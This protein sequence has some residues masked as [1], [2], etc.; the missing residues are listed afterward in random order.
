MC[1]S[2]NAKKK[3]IAGFDVG[4]SSL[5]VSIAALDSLSVTENR[6]Y[7]YRGYTE[8]SAGVVPVRIY[9]DN[10]K[11]VLRHIAG[12]YEIAAVS[13]STQMYSICGYIEGELAAYQWNCFWD[14]RK[15]AEEDFREEMRKS[16]CPA[17]SIYGAYKLCTV[18]DEERRNFR[19]YGIKECIIEDLTGTLVSDYTT[20]SACG[21][22]DIRKKSWNIPFIERLGFNSHD[23]PMVVK[24]NEVCGKVRPEL[25]PG[26]IPDMV[27]IPGLG[28]GVSA[29]YACREIS[30]FCGNIGTSMAARVITDK[31]DAESGV[32]VWTYAIDEKTYATGGISPN[33]CS[34]FTWSGKLGFEIA[35]KLDRK[36]ELLFLPWIHGERVPYWTSDLKG[37]FLGMKSDTTREDVSVAVLKGVSFTF[38]LME[39][40]LEKYCVGEDSIVL[41]G[42]A[43]NSK[44]VLEVVSGSIDREIAMV[45]HADYLCSTGAVLS[46]A[47]ALGTEIRNEIKVDS[48]ILPSGAY[49]EEFLKWQRLSQRMAEIYKEQ[50]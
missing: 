22:F 14:T 30:S 20:A 7:D 33:A 23:L 13:V 15:D 42:G 34:V 47:E 12:D 45:N 40:I 24:H 28:D 9:Q 31:I 43:S 17:D 41:A 8:L 18:S 46:A 21:L 25:F 2:V 16:G 44:A 50:Q 27:V 4:T 1:A 19:P 49:A 36:S 29:S 11:D 3:V 10:V 26:L 5:K 37:T 35:E 38:S 6:K 48:R 32:S 39:K